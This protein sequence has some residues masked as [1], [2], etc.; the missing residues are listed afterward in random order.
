MSIPAFPDESGPLY[1]A[2]PAGRLELMVD[3][4]EPGTERAGVA[5][6][7]HPNPPDGGTLHNKVVTMTGRA[8][9]E[10]GLAVVR[11]NFRGVGQSEGSFDQGR[12]EVLD[13]LAVTDWVR[14]QRPDDQLWLAGFS[15][16]SWVALQGARQVP[17]K[18]MISIAPP[19]GLRAFD[20]VLPPPCPWL[21]VMGEADDI[22]DP[23]KV[24]D[25][26]DSLPQ[27]PALVRM[28]D[29]GHFFH[30]R[31]MDLRGAIKNGVRR[32]LP[33]PRKS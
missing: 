19:V 22:V 2:G 13:L 14:R 25:W 6:I 17:V 29:T 16:G 23:Q 33:P 12:G 10:L 5:V 20:G 11:F 26:I 7:C 9:N 15:F 28:P 21:V 30:R 8:L 1:L 27:K 32:N 4:P 3:L 31:L 18:Q 24:Y